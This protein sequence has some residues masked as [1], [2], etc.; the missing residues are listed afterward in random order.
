L[1]NDS[2]DRKTGE[3]LLQLYTPYQG[4]QSMRVT[5]PTVHSTLQQ[6]GH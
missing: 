6:D 2:V 3:Y 5:L 1:R 4:L